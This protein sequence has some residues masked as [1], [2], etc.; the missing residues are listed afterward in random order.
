MHAIVPG[1]LC[2]VSALYLTQAYSV[3]L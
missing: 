1:R 3:E 2:S